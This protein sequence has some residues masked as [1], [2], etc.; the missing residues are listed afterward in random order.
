[1]QDRGDLQHPPAVGLTQRL[2]L[3]LA[4]DGQLRRH[5]LAGLADQRGQP[6]VVQPPQLRRQQVG[7]PLT[8][9]PP[10]ALVITA[11]GMQARGLQTRAERVGVLRLLNTPRPGQRL[12]RPQQLVRG[13]EVGAEIGG[14]FLPPLPGGVVLRAQRVVG[15]RGVVECGVGPGLEVEVRGQRAGLPGEHGV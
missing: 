2:G 8:S 3:R 11:L 10:L 1:M 12:R 14:V 6:A 7:R 15:T 5:Q 9:R 13:Q 4:A